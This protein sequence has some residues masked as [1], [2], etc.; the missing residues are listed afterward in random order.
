M[1][2]LEGDGPYMVLYE[3][4]PG[5]SLDLTTDYSVR[6]NGVELPVSSSWDGDIPGDE[7]AYFIDTSIDRFIYI[8]NHQLDAANDSFWQMQGEMTVLGFGRQPPPPAPCCTSYMNHFPGK[9]TYGLADGSTFADGS[10]EVNDAYRDLIVSQGAGAENPGGGSSSSSSS[11]SPK[12]SCSLAQPTSMKDSRCCPM[13]ALMG[14]RSLSMATLKAAFSTIP[15]L[16]SGLLQS[17][18]TGY[19]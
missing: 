11:S 1:T 6:S 17:W 16:T 15:T 5:G 9:F 18:E 2:V 7:W 19:L 4:T 8:A 13:T 12:T 3:G 14:G 10:R